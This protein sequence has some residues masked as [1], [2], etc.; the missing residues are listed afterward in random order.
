MSGFADFVILD[1]LA[2]PPPSLSEDILTT[3]H[4][5]GTWRGR[6]CAR[7]SLAPCKEHTDNLKTQARAAHYHSYHHQLS[8]PWHIG[9]ITCETCHIHCI[10]LLGVCLNKSYQYLFTLNFHFAFGLNLL[11]SVVLDVLLVGVLRAVSCRRLLVVREHQ[12]NKQ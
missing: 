1:N 9:P 7:T 2:S 8:S 5:K 12:L 3:F 6:H 11:R 4:G 10:S